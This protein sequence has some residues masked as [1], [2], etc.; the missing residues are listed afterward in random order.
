VKPLDRKAVV[1]AAVDTGVI[2]TAEEH[3]VG[4]FGNIIAGAIAADKPYDAPLVIGMIGVQ[5][6]FG[7]SGEPWELMKAFGL[8]AEH[9]AEKALELLKQ[10]K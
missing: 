7:Q 9:I 10:K 2:V 4:G 6:K 8:T 5:D 3:Q 1:A